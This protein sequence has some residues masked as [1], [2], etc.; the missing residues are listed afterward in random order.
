MKDKLLQGIAEALEC[1]SV[2]EATVLAEAGAWDSLAVVVVIGLIDEHCHAEVDGK[3]LAA[4]VTAG[5]VLRLAWITEA[6]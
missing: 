2:T 1:A 5:D 6:A 3:A 4:C